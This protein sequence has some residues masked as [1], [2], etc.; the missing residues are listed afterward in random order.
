MN[1]DLIRRKLI[2]KLPFYASIINSVQFKELAIANPIACTD[3]KDV[4]YNPNY[5]KNLTE[6]QVIFAF[7]NA[8][9][10]IGFHDVTRLEDKNALVW[11][12]ATDAVINEF[13]RK[14]GLNGIK[15]LIDI[16]TGSLNAEDL[17]NK[18]ME[19]EK[20]GTIQLNGDG[21]PKIHI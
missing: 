5:F 20:E 7:A 1:F 2:E 8:I 14:M 18:L 11:N 4:Y 15:G 12:I 3:G 17:Y 16:P 21:S 9:C 10:H 19:Q 13:L 6:E